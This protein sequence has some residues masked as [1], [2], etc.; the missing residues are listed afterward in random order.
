[1]SPE[2]QLLQSVWQPKRSPLK[3]KSSLMPNVMENWSSSMLEWF[4][5]RH[6][7]GV[8]QKPPSRTIKAGSLRIRK[9]FSDCSELPA[10]SLV[11][12]AFPLQMRGSRRGTQDGC[13]PWKFSL[14]P[15]ELGGAD[16]KTRAWHFSSSGRRDFRVESMKSS[17]V[18]KSPPTFWLSKIKIHSS[19]WPWV[20]P[21]LYN[22]LSQYHCSSKQTT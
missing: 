9:D 3:T 15:G 4:P 12:V 1:M 19:T 6:L 20:C 14:Q 8:E 16:L 22:N 21:R 13:L 5:T 17:E 10:N 18:R 11:T 2:A 7:L